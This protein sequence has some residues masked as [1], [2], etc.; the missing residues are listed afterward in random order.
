MQCLRNL[1]LLGLY[2]V[3]NSPTQMFV[4]SLFKTAKHGNKLDIYQLQI[5]LCHTYN[6]KGVR[7]FRFLS[8]VGM[9]LYV[10]QIFIP[11]LFSKPNCVC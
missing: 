7:I 5:S 11:F 9:L 6:K 4:N 3:L 1:F 8:C 2:K 10:L